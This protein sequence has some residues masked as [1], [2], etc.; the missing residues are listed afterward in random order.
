MRLA[1]F[2]RAEWI[3]PD[4]RSEEKEG[5]LAELVAPLVAS[6]VVSDA[7]N[8]VGVLLERERLGSTGIGEGIAIPHGKLPEIDR[9]VTVFARSRKGV[10]YDAMDGAPVHLFFLLLAPE[11]SASLHLKA[12][13]R[14]SR[15]LKSRS[16]RDALVS[17][18]DGA[19]LY[20]MIRQ[21]DDKN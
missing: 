19:A 9:V 20:E 1:D 7:E 4:L 15:L 16:F 14:I 21:E 11:D 17:C 3:I 8:V 18:P 6:Q 5:V 13:A 10:D 2:L 12:L